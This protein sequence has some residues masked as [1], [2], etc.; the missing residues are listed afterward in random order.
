[1]R[2]D[3]TACAGVLLGLLSA[4]H[5]PLRAEESA[6]AALVAP[7]KIEV[8]GSNIKQVDTET[9][10]PVQVLTQDDIAKSSSKTVTELLQGLPIASGPMVNDIFGFDSFSPGAS[11]LSLRGLGENS[12]LVLLNGRRLPV[13]GVA[14]YQDLLTNLDA[15]PLDAVE[16]VQILKSGGA[17][18]YGSSAVGGVVNIITRKDFHGVLVRADHQQSVTSGEFGANSANLTFG[19]GNVATDGFNVMAV[20]DTFHRNSVMWTHLLDYV[21]K[22]V[23]SHY[24]LF[25]TYS[26]LS[27]AGNFIDFNTGAVAAGTPCNPPEKIVGAFCEYPRYNDIQAIPESD[28]VNLMTSGSLRIGGNMTAFG[29]YA[30]SHLKTTYLGPHAGYVSS[31]ATT[32]WF[33]PQTGKL[34]TFNEPFLA[35]TSTL[36]PFSS[37][38]DDAELRYRFTDSPHNSNWADANQYRLLGGLRG[39]WEG[40]EWEAAAGAMGSR[41]VEVSFFGM[42][43]SAFRK[44]IGDYTQDTIDSQGALVSPDPNFFQQPGGY[45]LGGRNSAA[46]LNALFP[47]SDSTGKQTHYFADAKISGA[48][49]QMPAGPLSF[50]AGGDLHEERYTLTNSPNLTEGDL[51]GTIIQSA[52]ASRFYSAV[53]GELGIPVTKRFDA[54]IAARLDK[55]PDVAV[56][57]SPKA[58]LRYQA[59]GGLLLRSTFE[60]GFR[61]P[62]LVESARSTKVVGSVGIT[63]PTRCPQAVQLSNDLFNFAQSIFSNPN[64]TPAQIALANGALARAGTAAQNECGTIITEIATYN[65]KL[66]PETAR[67]FGLGFVLEPI[68]GY[69]L[70]LDY[71]NIKRK[72][73]INLLGLQQ[74]LNGNVPPGTIIS[75][76]PVGTGDPTFLAHD[77]VFGGQSDFA[78]YGV[79]TG[80]VRYI[81][82]GFQNL[83][84]QLSTGVDINVAIRSRPVWIGKVDV[85]I[86]AT[87]QASFKDDQVDPTFANL[88]GHYFYPKWF[89][90]GNFAY[91]V[92]G[93]THGVRANFQ[94][95]TTLSVTPGDGFDAAGCASLGW[96][97]ALCRVASYTTWDYFFTYSGIK[98]LL[99]NVNLQNIFARKYPTDLRA[100]FS[101]AGTVPVYQ[102]DAQGRML[103]VSLQYRF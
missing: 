45:V 78:R 10:S 44:Y 6:P 17:A 69:S 43:S 62:S 19:T 84:N 64:A 49:V 99:V 4:W 51:V 11:S 74:I 25:G 24:P 60:T 66:K 67:S 33:V 75:R 90:Y 29:E 2:R 47:E 58:G 28:R 32:T 12:T 94:S 70:S 1:M 31:F 88:A 92:S 96:S 59:G 71:F 86:N 7:E 20:L 63:D 98:N 34:M 54:D 14:N 83:G 39:A 37:L 61:A 76:A 9:A 73:Q 93:F 87:Y 23:T 68:K 5:P 95:Q 30:F 22:G 53:F 16:Q 3:R 42:S 13:F 85:D 38:G 89:A 97:P 81:Q 8:V 102:V 35:A 21:N 100:V 50:A 103:K 57:A 40:S 72:D 46:V 15:I 27:H 26:T 56:H 48:L 91:T 18:V 79:T 77:P 80:P 82:H 41:A 52:D 65:P 55:F 101:S 36:N